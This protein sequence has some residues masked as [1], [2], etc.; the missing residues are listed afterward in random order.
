[1]KQIKDYIVNSL[2]WVPQYAELAAVVLI[3]SLVFFGT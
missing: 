3:I 2:M 1:M